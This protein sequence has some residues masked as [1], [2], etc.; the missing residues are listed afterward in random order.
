MKKSLLI[1]ALIGI[2]AGGYYF[3]QQNNAVGNNQPQIISKPNSDAIFKARIADLA[4]VRQP[5][6]QWRGKI[7]VVNFW[8][9]WCPPCRQEV[10]EFIAL[11]KQYGDQGL[12]FVGIALDEKAK[13]QNFMDEVGINYP[14]LV[15]D[16]EAVAL[17]QTSGNRLGGLPYTVVIDQKGN[18]VATEMGALS[19]EKLIT[20]LTPLLSKKS[21]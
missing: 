18:I 17:A 9:T 5:L 16:L 12:Q 19:K 8:A 3:Y 6:A 11:Q 4:G 20:I 13:I 14:V 2:A 21:V 1:V 15:G 7:L 10:P